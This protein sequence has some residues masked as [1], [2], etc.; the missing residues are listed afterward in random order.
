MLPPRPKRGSLLNRRFPRVFFD[1]AELD[2]KVRGVEAPSVRAQR[3]LEEGL[4]RFQ[5]EMVV[6]TERA[7]ETRHELDEDKYEKVFEE[8]Q[9]FQS[10]LQQRLQKLREQ[11]AVR[12]QKLQAKAAADGKAESGNGAP[13][14]AEDASDEDSGSD[15]EFDWR[16]KGFG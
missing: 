9:E 14:A 10:T 3:E 16:A 5:R 6:E 7:E 13:E 11:A 4:K 2:A 15:V 8:E 12:S 1:D